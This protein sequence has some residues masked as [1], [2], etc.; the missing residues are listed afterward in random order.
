MLII[1]E[2]RT[3][4]I[5][6]SSRTHGYDCFTLHLIKQTIHSQWKFRASNLQKK[7]M[8]I[9]IF[10]FTSMACAWSRYN[11]LSNRIILQYHSPVM[12]TERLGAYQNKKSRTTWVTRY[13]TAFSWAI[14]MFHI[15]STFNTNDTSEIQICK[16]HIYEVL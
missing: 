2:V 14:V 9:T 10:F 16:K 13:A 6:H 8:H 1:P 5:A 12:L 15:C 3:K 7:K 11:S 4:P